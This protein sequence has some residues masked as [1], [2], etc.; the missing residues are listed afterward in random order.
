MMGRLF[1][2]AKRWW[3]LA[4]VFTL[5]LSLTSCSKKKKAVGPNYGFTYCDGTLGSFD[6]YVIPKQ[7]TTGY[8]ELS[9]I[10]VQLDDPGDIV[11]VTIANGSR[12]YKSLVH[13]V[14]AVN[15]QEIYAG[16]LSEADLDGYDILDISLFD[17][18]GVGYLEQ[19]P[20]KYA[21]CE[22]PLP[23]DDL[24]NASSTS[25]SNSKIRQ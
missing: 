16:T 11:Q 25:G 5:A 6:V 7:G 23:G 3:I 21:T 10:P 8:Y 13:Q 14:V 20:A 22:L 24:S 1:V 17:G 12:A 19:A 18:S 2:V 4:L 15:D 9:I